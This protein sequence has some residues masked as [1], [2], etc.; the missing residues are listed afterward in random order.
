MKKITRIFT[1]LAVVSVSA[2]TQAKA[3]VDIGVNLQLNRPAAYERNE[4][5]HPRRPSAAHM[6]VAEEWRWNPGIRNYEYVP[7]RW[8]IPPRP[9]LVWVRG[10][11]VKRTYHPGYR[12]VPGQWR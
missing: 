2:F 6:W 5:E 10:H 12:W 4:R 1:V 7:G 9:G 11:W 8:A 3:Q